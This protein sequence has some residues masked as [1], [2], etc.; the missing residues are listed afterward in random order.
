[1]WFSHQLWFLGLLFW[2]VCNQLRPLASM[3]GAFLVGS[4]SE[5]LW[6]SASFAIVA[7]D[8][9]CTDHRWSGV[10]PGLPLDV[11]NL[12]ENPERALLQ[13]HEEAAFPADALVRTRAPWGE[14]TCGLA[15]RLWWWM[16]W[17]P[18]PPP[19]DTLVSFPTKSCPCLPQMVSRA[20]SVLGDTKDLLFMLRSLWTAIHFFLFSSFP[21]Y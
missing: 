11:R 18:P 21:Q 9:L 1:M 7:L 5:F 8:F 14:H 3:G 20:Q 12:C 15:P 2:G 17:A 4:R 6:D 16:P 10:G 19:Q 13:P